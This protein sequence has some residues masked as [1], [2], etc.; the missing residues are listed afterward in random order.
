[1]GGSRVPFNVFQH[2]TQQATG[3]CTQFHAANAKTWLT[4][5]GSNSEDFVIESLEQ[6]TNVELANELLD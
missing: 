5:D 4:A 1:L 6:R 2:Q 3:S